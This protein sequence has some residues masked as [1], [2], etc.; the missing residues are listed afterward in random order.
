MIQ[1]DLG[2]ATTSYLD[3]SIIR[4]VL[5][6]ILSIFHSFPFKIL[7]KTRTKCLNFNFILVLYPFYIT[8]NLFTN[9]VAMSK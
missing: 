2:Y 3:I 8:D 6:C 5:Q 1:L 9:T 7:L 4:T